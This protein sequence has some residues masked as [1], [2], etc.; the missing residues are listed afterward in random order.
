MPSV[1][2][3]G[4]AGLRILIVEDEYFLADDVRQ[5]LNEQNV[6]VLGPVPTMTEALRLINESHR[7]DCAV[8]DVN[9]GGKSVFPIS[10]ALME[11]NIPFLFATGYGSTQIPAPFTG[12]PRLE[13]PFISSALVAAL[14]AIIPA[15]AP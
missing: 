10:A 13:K 3:K 15:P 1:A 8:L 9:L 2:G 14:E 11:R 12:A 7:I 5:I 6:H 4:L